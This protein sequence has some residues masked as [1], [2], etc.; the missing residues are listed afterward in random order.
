MD[1]FQ[2]CSYS[3]AHSHTAVCILINTAL[4]LYIFLCT[5]PYCCCAVVL[6]QPYCCTHCF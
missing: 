1:L 3:C 2:C 5:Q 6:L 4:L